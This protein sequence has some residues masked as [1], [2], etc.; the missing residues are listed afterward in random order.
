[1]QGGFLDRKSKTSELNKI[2]MFC[3]GLLLGE[4][5]DTPTIWIEIKSVQNIS[6]AFLQTKGWSEDCKLHP[7][8]SRLTA[9]AGLYGVHHQSHVWFGQLA[10]LHFL[11]VNSMVILCSNEYKRP[12][13][14]EVSVDIN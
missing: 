2:S 11:P 7:Q 6:L 9:V 12:G 3:S 8:Q 1:M 14:S 10:S 4:M 13:A 5:L